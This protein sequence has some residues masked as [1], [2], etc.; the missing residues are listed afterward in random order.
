M[1][2][3]RVA[4]KLAL[5]NVS[6]AFLVSLFLGAASAA[7]CTAQTAGAPADYNRVDRQESDRQ[8][9]N[10]FLMQYDLPLR[11]DPW[12]NAIIGGLVTGIMQGAGEGVLDFLVSGIFDSTVDLLAPSDLSDLS[13]FYPDL[14][15]FDAYADSERES[16]DVYRSTKTYESTDYIDQETVRTN[17][18]P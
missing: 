17:R 16:S 2:I 8:A 1:N 18:I 12:G 6:R 5:A 3:G 15:G 14:S 4:I 9:Q 11:P 13:D 7:P 10:N